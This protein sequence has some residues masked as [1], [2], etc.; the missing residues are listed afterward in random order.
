M[1]WTL[2]AGI[3]IQWN[4]IHPKSLISRGSNT[5][6]RTMGKTFS[7]YID[8]DELAQWIEDLAESD[9]F[10]NMSHVFQRAVSEF[11]SSQSDDI[12]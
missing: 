11:R 4:P 10:R 9:E 6:V 12:L 2:K 7:P 8:D 3:N 1:Y 5:Y